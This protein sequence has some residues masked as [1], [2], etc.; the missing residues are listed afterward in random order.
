MM[1]KITKKILLAALLFASCGL[2]FTACGELETDENV[3]TITFIAI[4]SVPEAMKGEV[5]YEKDANGNYV[6]D[7][8]GQRVPVR[9]ENGNVV[10]E[11]GQ[12]IDIYYDA[13][14]GQEVAVATWDGSSPGQ[15]VIRRTD[16]TSKL[17]NFPPNPVKPGDWI[18]DGWYTKGGTRVTEQTIFT[19]DTRLMAVWKAGASIRTPE[20]P[21]FLGLKD[22]LEDIKGGNPDDEYELTITENESLVPMTLASPAKKVHIILNGILDNPDPLRPLPYL[23]ISESGSL[24]TIGN[25]VTLEL[26]NARL[27][28]NDRNTKSLLTVN[29]G[30]LLI[31]GLDEFD[32]TYIFLNGSEDERSGGGVTVN[33]GGVLIM[34]GGDIFECSV[35]ARPYDDPTGWPGGG[36]VNVR[37]GTFHMYGGN[38]ER[39]YGSI[40]GGAV[41]VDLKGLFTMYGGQLYDNIA[42]YGGGVATYRGGLFIME[43]GEIKENLARDGSGI[44]VDAGAEDTI[45]YDPRRPAN[46][47]GMDDM[48]EYLGV[49]LGYYNPD[50]PENDP[51]KMEGFYMRGGSIIDNH[52]VADGGGI[53]NYQGGIVYMTAGTIRGNIAD[54]FGG[55]VCN[56]GLFIMI[57]GN[58]LSNRAGY[59]GGVLAGLNMFAFEAGKINSNTASQ[60]GG[61]V[62]VL[63]G[64]F[65]M[66]SADAEIKSN[67]A[68]YFGGG[69]AIYPSGVFLMAG[70]TLSENSDQSYNEGTIAFFDSS[71]PKLLGY[72]LYGKRPANAIPG[73][74]AVIPKGHWYPH[75]VTGEN[76]EWVP[77]SYLVNHT[78]NDVAHV[79][80][81]L[82]FISNRVTVTVT[83]GVLSPMTWTE[84]AGSAYDAEALK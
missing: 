27:Q 1:H 20:G 78:W 63:E 82:G 49:P 10:Y 28:G 14:S 56:M 39:C 18:F 44:F 70:G 54:D 51:R 4:Y 17:K 58:I 57:D 13:F 47:Q 7:A 71:D 73:D 24:F 2:I 62:F 83:D 77:D 32:K 45:P 48:G 36:G 29:D 3:Y 9:D 68:R 5:V 12:T 59:G 53:Y 52:S 25:N 19:T 67:L 42:P 75:P 38:M 23:T 74:P 16:G 61:G 55:G 22:I 21:V 15:S 84:H 46:F 35:H 50:I 81:A 76:H 66:L 31:I 65:S 64:T 79:V 26:R 69:V 43:G 34:N 30:G 11:D 8:Q 41:L 6:R 37:G 33:K 40:N 60:A 80:A 72:A